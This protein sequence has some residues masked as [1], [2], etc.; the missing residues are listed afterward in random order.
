MAEGEKIIPINI[1]DEM[2]GA[3]I[4]YSMSVIISR[5]LPDVRDGLKPVH[6]RVLY[7]MSELGVS[8]NKAYKKSARIVGEVL[9]KYHPHGDSSVYDTMVRM[10][11]DWSLR[12]PLVDGQGNF[13]SIDGDSP[14]AMRYTEARLKRL[15]DELLGDLEKDT[16]DFQPNFDDS[17]EEP[18]V[19]PAKFPNLLVNGSSGIAVGMATN[20]APHN[21]TE[22]VDG[23]V[24]YLA[25]PEITVQELM[26]FVKAPDFPTGGVIYGYEGVRQALETG[27]GRVV[28][29]AKTH[30]ETTPTGKEQIVVTEVPYMVNKAAMIQRTAELINEKKIEGISDLRDESDRDGLRV[31]YDL[32]RDA[33]PQ[34]V[35][36]NLFKYTQLQ[37]TFGVNN[38]AL[39]KGRPM[40]L[41]LRDLIV[42]F[43]DH[44]SEVVIRRTKFELAEAQKRAHI[45]EGLLI[46]LDHLDEVIAL[47]RASRDP[48]L[49]R[50][51]LIERFALSDVQARAILDMR[52][53]RLTGLERDK[54]VNEYQE[55]MKLID[56]LK[57]VLESPEMQRDIIR[58][59]LI[60]IRD[61]YGDS[62]RTEIEYAGG[63]ID[64]ESLIA[65]ESMVITI[66]NEGY[67]KRTSLDE[68]RA[69]GRGGLGSRGA[70]SKEADFTEHLFVASTHDF[71]LLFTEGGRLYWIKAYELPEGG[72]AAKGR[73]I[74]NLIP[75]LANDPVRSV[76]NVRDLRDPD[77][78]QNNYLMF[79]TE[80]GTVKKT[81]LEAY[82]RPRAAGINAITINEGDRLLDVQLTTGSSE[83]IL[84]SK[85]GRAV[86]FNEANVRPMGRTAA[87][88]RGITLAEDVDDRVVGMVCLADPNKELLVVSETGYGKRSPIDDYRIT[89]RGAKGVSTLKITDK[90]G[91]L[92]AIKDVNDD[93]DLMIINRSGI[94]IRLRVADVRS[95]GR[96]TQ[97]VRLIKINEGDEISSVA[98]VAAEDKELDEVENGLE[99]QEGSPVELASEQT[100][101]V[102]TLGAE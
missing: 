74:Q 83:V 75:E 91:S 71:L 61:R 67:I 68:Y 44:R 52:L 23:I 79:C 89:N 22:V 100:N 7:G 48:E 96:A 35:L 37:S 46:A 4:D 78:A 76:L 81:T 24:A 90:T 12:Y 77:Y 58:T 65:E 64:F 57:A 70:S 82:S 11:Q 63:D 19:M 34:V 92:V 62:R 16:V 38:V 40:T 27:R 80:Q 87:G 1:E 50:A 101:D 13:G 9:G 39:V 66:S 36:N 60:D 97:G 17:L 43:V 84:A 41:N 47:I 55:L 10:A 14:A 86:R 42:H 54:I 69:Q 33:V 26:E 56:H 45:L 95:I 2:R 31:V 28:M 94:T 25:N 72:K 20:M 15:A 6:R 88:V 3:Y 5:A 59:E 73:P 53:Q 30:F 21:L 99:Q 93:D 85:Q 32:K 49:A 29:R 51:Q 8:Y 98:K 102:E 18:S